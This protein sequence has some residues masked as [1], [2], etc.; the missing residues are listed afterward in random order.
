M[1]RTFFCVVAS[2]RRVLCDD[3]RYTAHTIIMIRIFYFVVAINLFGFRH[4]WFTR[5]PTPPLSLSVVPFRPRPYNDI[6]SFAD[7]S[8]TST[9][10]VSAC[11]PA[12]ARFP[13]PDNQFDRG[14]CLL[15]PALEVMAISN[16]RW[17]KMAKY[18]WIDRMFDR[19]KRDGKKKA[20]QARKYFAKK[21]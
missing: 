14:I 11:L 20:T 19:W 9:C 1:W 6:H 4:P 3:I 15:Q 18:L 21:K 7:F 17:I 12:C 16:K 2:L 13:K 8:L 5:S 10:S